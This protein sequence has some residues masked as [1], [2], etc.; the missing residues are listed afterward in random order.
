[1]EN[2]TDWKDE[3]IDQARQ[4][5]EQKEKENKKIQ[6]S[7]FLTLWV[8][9]VLAAVLCIGVIFYMCVIATVVG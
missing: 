6:S 7:L 8:N 9:A 5:I 3:L 2:F 4:E 1:M